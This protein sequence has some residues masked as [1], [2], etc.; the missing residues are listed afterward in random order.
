MNHSFYRSLDNVL[1]VINAFSFFSFYYLHFFLSICVHIYIWEYIWECTIRYDAKVPRKC[2]EISIAA[3]M[4][5]AKILLKWQW[6]SMNLFKS[7][8]VVYLLS[9]IR[10]IHSMFWKALVA[11]YYGIV[12]VPYSYCKMAEH[13]FTF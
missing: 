5:V 6:R 4:K 12:I 2:W 11:Q 10:N 3:P 13:L 9:K 1:E 7:K 8:D